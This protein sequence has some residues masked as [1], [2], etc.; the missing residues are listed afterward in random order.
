MAG[1]PQKGSL[2]EV[3]CVSFPKRWFSSSM[4]LFRGV[5]IGSFGFLL[6]VL[7]FNILKLKTA[8]IVVDKLLGGYK[9]IIYIYIIYICKHTATTFLN[10]HLFGQQVGG[11][12]YPRSISIIQ[13]WRMTLK[14][15]DNQ[16]HQKLPSLKHTA[17]K[18]VV[19]KLLPTWGRLGLFREL[20]LLILG[21]Q[22]PTL[23]QS[24]KCTTI[25][26]SIIVWLKMGCFWKEGFARK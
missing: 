20:L 13:G 1:N 3:I 22:G 7:Q 14:E 4:L 16:M 10:D 15:Y 9:H 11:Y 17:W 24:P 12:T 19:G 21:S 6:V 8:R 18:I 25:D 23:P 26:C 2:E 5:W